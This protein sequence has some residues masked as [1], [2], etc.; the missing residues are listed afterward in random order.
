[1]GP[2]P[3]SVLQYLMRFKGFSLFAVCVILTLV[4]GCDNV[5]WGGLD[6]ILRPP[7][8]PPSSLLPDTELE[9]EERPPEPLE[10][11]PLVYLVDRS[12]AAG[13][14]LPVAEWRNGTY[15]ALPDV[16]ETPDLLPR[17]PLQR[18][19]EG[20]EF[21]L[22]D[23]GMRAGTLISDGSVEADSTYCGIRPA[24]RG[25]V[26]LRPGAEG[27]Q[28]FFAVRKADVESGGFSPRPLAVVPHPGAGT[29]AV[30]Q[31]GALSL[32]RFIIP[33]AD[34]PW[35]PAIPDILRD[36]RSF[37]LE[38]GGEALAASLVFGDDLSVGTPAVTGYGLFALGRRDGDQWRP[39]WSWYQTARQGKAFPRLRAAG[40]LREEGEPELILEVFGTEERWLAI[41]GEREGEWGLRYQDACGVSPATGALRGWD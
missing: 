29:A 5:S 28:V 1:M 35:P 30:R 10:L 8:P 31:A 41:L 6:V 13:R 2:P 3:S 23:R 25:T 27:G 39:F 33:R 15:E 22:M 36:T 26:E 9:S 19:E 21:V 17:F 11:G 38:D 32:A 37:T 18:W 20:T 16:G 7:P 4:P 24:G 34:V 14:F 40:L 12:G